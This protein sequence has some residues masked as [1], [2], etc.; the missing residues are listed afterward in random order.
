MGIRANAEEFD[1]ESAELLSIIE[2]LRK[3]GGGME[4][5]LDRLASNLET[6]SF[7]LAVVGQFKRGKTSL[8][9]AI[10]GQKLLPTAVLPLTSIIT[11]VRYGP[12]L[13]IIAVFKD[14]REAEIC[15]E[16]IE[17]YVTE[18]LNPN[19]EKNVQR[20][21][22]E[23]PSDFLKRGVSLVDTPGIGSVYRH[24]TDVAFRFL[25]DADAVIFVLSADPPISDA[26]CQFLAESSK[27]ARKFFF[28]LN[29]ADYLEDS[30]IGEVLE[31]NRRTIASKMGL[32]PAS[33]KLF[34]LSAKNALE[35]KAGGKKALEAGKGFIAFEYAL[36]DFIVSQK[37]RFVIQVSG[38]RLMFL[39]EELAN[40]RMIEKSGL[41]VS[42]K[43]LEERLRKF[44]EGLKQIL[45][46]KEYNYE[47]IDLEQK[48]ILDA[49][50]EDIEG[51]KKSSIPG[52]SKK[53]M[54]Y[55][56]SLENRNNEEFWAS[57]DDFRQESI[58]HVLE[59]WR[60]DEEEKVSKMFSER[61]QK[62]SANI[63]EIISEVE[64][65]A[66]GLFEVKIESRKTDE[67]LTMESSFYFKL[68]KSDET[69]MSSM[70]D[71]FLPR[72]LFK[73]RILSRLPQE[74]REDFDRN[75]GRVRYDFLERMQRSASAFK[76]ALGEKTDSAIQGI[77]LA[78]ENAIRVRAQ[79]EEKTRKRLSQIEKELAELRE[80]LGRL[81]ASEARLADSHE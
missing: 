27:Y 25:P 70:L 17:G 32:E 39:A 37:G 6:E 52:L 60:N 3:F 54:D 75:C 81:D 13:R 72:P 77:R 62:Y 51:L 22:I 36:E 79:G 80:I 64:R 78:N 41:A 23:I 47:L 14:S 24:N 71:P 4:E 34:P 63:N 46:K 31:F 5:K 56:H 48:K 76:F 2:K 49:I 43:E 7:T 26:E 9:N 19:N 42:R 20:I 59:P 57:V 66:S 50:D 45:Y 21:E 69:R 35:A 74:I 11:I 40:Q 10:L 33:I 53:I 44:E 16:D 1:S 18:K 68:S 67:S 28:V 30:E 58:L 61:M 8:I 38:S 55:A 29:K 12:R 15:R 73:R 65:L